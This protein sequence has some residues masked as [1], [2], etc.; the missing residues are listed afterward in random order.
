MKE[1]LKIPRLPHSWAVA[2]LASD[3]GTLTRKDEK[4]E[5]KKARMKEIRTRDGGPLISLWAAAR[6]PLS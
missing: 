3:T 2:G 5:K 4:E 6:R 1:K